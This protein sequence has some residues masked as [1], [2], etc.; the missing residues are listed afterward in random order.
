MIIFL[1]CLEI[2]LKYSN[3]NIIGNLVD[4]VLVH[5]G[6]RQNSSLRNIKKRNF[7]PAKDCEFHTC[8]TNEV[9]HLSYQVLGEKTC[10]HLVNCY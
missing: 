9:A 4:T 3:K 8:P 2:Y 10:V 5:R 6:H 1:F 7:A